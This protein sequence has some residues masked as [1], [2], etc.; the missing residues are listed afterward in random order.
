M[1]KSKQGKAIFIEPPVFEKNYIFTMPVIRAIGILFRLFPSFVIA[2]SAEILGTLA[3]LLLPYRKQVIRTQIK[4]TIGR[5]MTGREIRRLM[6][7]NYVH[8]AHLLF[9][10]FILAS[11]DLTKKDYFDG[12]FRI[13]GREEFLATLGEGKGLVVVNAHLGVWE[14]LGAMCG[15]YLGPVTVPV[16]FIK[17]RLFQRM[18]ERMQANPSVTLVDS[19][20]GR[21]RIITMVNALRKGQVVAIFMDQYN[22]S[23]EFAPFFGHAARTTSAAAVLARK[24]KSPVFMAYIARNSALKY[25]LV[26]KQLELPLAEEGG[27]TQ[28]I[29][30]SMVACFNRAIEDA[31]RQYPDQWLWAHRRFK[32]NPAFI[33][34]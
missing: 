1:I 34:D 27:A 2:F 11:L 17:S 8:Y 28:E 12:H 33:Y 4:K 16:K 15:L 9:E 29:V 32:E 14:A 26:L 6:R 3:W 7:A 13:D 19:R 10:F 18:R 20:M 25:T 5:E 31:I 22:P 24:M 30:A 21:E 23:E